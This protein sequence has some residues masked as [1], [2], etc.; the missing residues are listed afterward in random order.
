M[1]A[2]LCSGIALLSGITVSGW[3][4]AGSGNSCCFPGS[5]SCFVGSP[6]GGGV[7]P[8]ADAD[9]PLP[10][11]LTIAA[12]KAGCKCGAGEAP[13]EAPK[14]E[15]PAKVDAKL[16]TMIVEGMTCAG[17]AKT[18]SKAVS[19]IADVES[20]EVDVKTKTVTVTP[21]AGKILSAKDLWEAVEKA[22]YKP[23]KFEGPAGKFVSKP[24]A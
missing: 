18:V 19:A 24:T 1:I 16:S 17:C 21:K 23:S 15:H 13:K 12:P 11:K 20:A 5:E 3:A 14:V 6:C 8:S 10:L 2:K 7:A 4:L 9:E 22:G